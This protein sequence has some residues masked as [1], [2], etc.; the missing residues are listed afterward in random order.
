[1]QKYS[2]QIQKPFL[3]APGGAGER[4]TKM[5]KSRAIVEPII[6]ELNTIIINTESGKNLEICFGLDPHAWIKKMY[7]H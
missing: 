2:Y 3:P 1:M 6:M 5:H 4:R 7:L